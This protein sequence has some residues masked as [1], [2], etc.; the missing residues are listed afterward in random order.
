[1][2]FRHKF[3][4]LTLVSNSTNSFVYCASI[5]MSIGYYRIR[6]DYTYFHGISKIPWWIS[7]FIERGCIALHAMSF[8]TRERIQEDI[9]HN[10]LSFR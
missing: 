1:M 10:A 2:I 6:I 3:G 5:F 8:L 7:A 4:E 9:F